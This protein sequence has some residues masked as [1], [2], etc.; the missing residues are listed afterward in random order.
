VKRGQQELPLGV[1]CAL[2]SRE[3]KLARPRVAER[4]PSAWKRAF[5][6]LKSP[7]RSTSAPL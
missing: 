6:W 3:L 1:E 2:P 5:N 7:F 4:A